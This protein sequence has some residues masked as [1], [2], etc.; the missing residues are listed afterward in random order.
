LRIEQPPRWPRAIIAL[1]HR[2]FRL[3]WLGQLVSLTGT[4]MQG[5]AQSWLVLTLTNSALLLGVVNAAGSL[6]ILFFTLFGGVLADRHDKRR[7]LVLAQSLMMLQ[8]VLL[9]TLTILHVVTTWEII[10]LTAFLGVVNSIEIPTRQAFHVELV[11]KEDLQNAISLNSSVFNATRIAGPPIAGFIV[12][13]TGVAGCFVV[14][15]LSFLAVLAGLVA[16]R[17]PF[18]PKRT[19]RASPVRELREG[20]SYVRH[21][22]RI[23]GLLLNLAGLSIFGLPYAVLMPI[24]ARDVLHGGP[25]TLGFLSAAA[26]VGALSAAAGLASRGSGRARFETRSY[27]VFAGGLI[28]SLGLIAVS[29]SRTPWLT[30][31]LLAVIGA[32]MVSA[33]ATT[34][35]LLQTLVPDQ[36]RGRVMSVHVVTFLGLAPVGSLV[37]GSLA[38]W[39]GAPGAFLFH[40]CVSL[41]VAAAFAYFV[42]PRRTQGDEL[43]GSANG[44]P[45]NAPEYS[46]S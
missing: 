32:A 35:T 39:F 34:N 29:F 28:A 1:R 16:M 3:F 2:N 26:G 6:P 43:R 45:Q 11:G 23:R 4:W 15:A 38:H 18:P 40:G 22:S 20:L 25:R 31:T 46:E 27:V 36:L 21:T 12:A 5:L 13:S 30:A 10:A 37:A 42:L 8:A 41:V 19:D 9:A 44:G 14:N 17:G 7:V 24:I 33:V